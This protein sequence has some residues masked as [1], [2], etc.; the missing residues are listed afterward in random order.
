VKNGP[1]E[2]ILIE[3]PFS[4]DELHGS[5]PNSQVVPPGQ[6]AGFNIVFSSKSEMDFVD[7]FN[8]R[9]NRIHKFTLTVS[10]HVIPIELQLSPQTITF[11][12]AGDSIKPT[13]RETLVI[14]NLSTSAAE[15]SWSGFTETTFSINIEHGIQQTTTLRVW[16]V[17]KDDRLLLVQILFKYLRQTGESLSNPVALSKFAVLATPL[18]NSKRQ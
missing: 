15:F 3:L 9:V 4:T 5:Y 2:Y 14:R 18:V 7:S 1:E 13:S 17:G 10:A 8:S 11:H 6:V 16:K 12:F